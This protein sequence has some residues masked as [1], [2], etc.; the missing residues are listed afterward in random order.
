M[1]ALSVL[2]GAVGSQQVLA[3]PLGDHVLA[4]WA[5]STTLD[6]L[7]STGKACMQKDIRTCKI[8]QY[9]LGTDGYKGKSDAGS[10]IIQCL[11]G[12]ISE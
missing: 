12:C 10:N 6:N 3:L 7:L 4:L 8:R 2:L 5:R 1:Y 9:G 11:A